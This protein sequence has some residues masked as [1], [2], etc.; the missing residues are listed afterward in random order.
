MNIVKNYMASTTPQRIPV[1]HLPQ[2]SDSCAL[3]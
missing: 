2:E 3:V 1:Q